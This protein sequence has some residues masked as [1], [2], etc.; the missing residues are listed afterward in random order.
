MRIVTYTLLFLLMLTS[1]T[2][3]GTIPFDP[4]RGLVEIKVVLD[5]RIE[6]IFGIDTG[7]DR[8]YIDKTFAQKNGLK[9][10]EGQPQR[11]VTG[12]EGNSKASPVAVRSLEIAGERLYNLDATAIDMNAII[13]DGRWGRPDGLIGYDLLRRFYVTVDYPNRTL[14]LSMSE[15][16]FLRTESLDVVPFRSRR[17]LIMV[18]VTFNDTITVP[19]ILDYCASQVFISANLATQLGMDSSKDKRGIVPQVSIS[20]KIVTQNVPVVV[21]DYTNLEEGLRGIKFEG[22]LG[23]GFLFRHKITIDYKHNR[24]YRHSR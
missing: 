5:G 2:I 9:V 14:E 19:M 13:P 18:D 24:I 17:H 16:K 20:N 23:A 7:A 15:P 22:I 4:L 1:M 10:G 12:A 11:P 8:L 6:G 3:S 21:T